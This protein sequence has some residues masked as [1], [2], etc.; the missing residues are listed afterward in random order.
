MTVAIL[1]VPGEEGELSFHAVSGGKSSLGR[2]RG[3]A[4]DAISAQLSDEQDGTLVVVQSFHSDRY[5]SA[6]Q[7]RRLAELMGRW[8]HA[9]Q[10]GEGLPDSE[11]A[12]LEA[13]IEME[14]RAA[15]QRAAALADELGR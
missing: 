4:L 9:G 12:E 15:G 5:F 7:Q 1:P 2:T 6:P 13:L 10:Q 11:Q 8:S 3:E 14:V